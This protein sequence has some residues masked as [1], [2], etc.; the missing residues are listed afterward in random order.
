MTQSGKS[1]GI[2][3]ALKALRSLPRFQGRGH[4]SLLSIGNKS[5]LHC[6]RQ[7]EMGDTIV[8]IFGKISFAQQNIRP[9][10]ASYLSYILKM[11]VFM[12]PVISF[13]L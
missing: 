8:A 13:Y 3:F 4:R 6:R 5:R 11:T 7:H 1:S 12:P 2:T 9:Y 10:N